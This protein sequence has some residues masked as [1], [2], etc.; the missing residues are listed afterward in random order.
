MAISRSIAA[1]LCTKPELELVEAS[2]PPDVKQLTPGR[3]RQKVERTRRIRDKYR[4]LSKRQRG[5]SRGKAEPRRSR[6]AQGSA[7]TERK[8]TLFDE[9]LNRFE[10]QLARAGGDLSPTA[11]EHSTG[12]SRGERAAAG[13]RKTGARKTGAKQTGAKQTG[14]KQTAMKK[15]GAKQTAMKQTGAK[16]PGM[17]TGAKQAGAKKDAKTQVGRAPAAGEAKAAPPGKS[18][19]SARKGARQRPDSAQQAQPKAAGA[20]GRAAGQRSQRR[21]DDRNTGR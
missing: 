1:R 2:F 3:L 8:A 5:E 12:R 7:N 16:Q 18:G 14:A 17:K 6:P 4:D 9:T 20:H 10:K 11:A 15:T 19:P 13:A 21:R